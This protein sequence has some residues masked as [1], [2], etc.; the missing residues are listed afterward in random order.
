MAAAYSLNSHPP[1]ARSPYN[2]S[3]TGRLFPLLLALLASW[4][5]CARAQQVIAVSNSPVIRMQMRSG[6][7]TVRTWERSQVQISSTT[8]VRARHLEAQAVENGLPP[9]ITIFDA[10]IQTR[11]GPII[12]PP[13]SFPLG[14]VLDDPHDGVLIFGGDEGA[15]ITL[16]IPNST[17]MLWAIV[18]SGRIT[19][20]DYRGGTFVALIHTGAMHLQN[21]SGDGYAQ[22]ARG[23]MVV[24]NSAFNRIRA[25]TAVGNIIFENCNVRQIVASSVNGSIAYDNGTFV[26][27][28]AR[29]ESQNG[30]VAIGVAGG[31]A[32]ID[33]HSAQGKIFSGFS[34]AAAVS[35]STTDA[36][37]I[38]APGGPV[39]TANSEHGGVYLYSGA[40]RS[41][42]RLQGAWEPIGRIL[43]PL[44]QKLSHRRHI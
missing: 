14:S 10:S 4:P 20:N 1:C 17:A 9:E 11:D 5:A 30:N 36:Q 29:F 24:R 42:G 16:T 38:L 43:R 26:P 32:L 27:G 28:I 15:E 21:V 37:A 8:P 34:G 6:S 40:L 19:I 7:V 23:P 22:V 41:H 12:L 3:V 13:E 35:G 18:G 2:G 25:R 31:G 33:A 39:I 44:Q